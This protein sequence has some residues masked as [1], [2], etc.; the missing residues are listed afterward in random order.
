[1][2]TGSR[3]PASSVVV[4]PAAERHATLSSHIASTL[5]QRIVQGMIPDGAML[6]RQEDLQAEFDVGHPSLREALRMLET[7]GLI[8][9]RRGKHGGAVVHPPKPENAAFGIGLVLEHQ[10]TQ[11]DDV[12]RVL[13]ALDP[14]C[15]ALCAS[16]ADRSTTVLPLLREIHRENR[17]ASDPMTFFRCSR[18]FH[19]ALTAHC[20]S[21]TLALIVDALEALWSAQIAPEAVASLAANQIERALAQHEAIMAAIEAGDAD[22][23]RQLARQHTIEGLE[24]LYHERLAPAVR[25]SDRSHL[26]FAKQ[27]RRWLRDASSGS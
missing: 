18:E 4:G 15:A 16:R 9:V 3:M 2:T 1:M 27:A 14:E 13:A 5:R 21:N 6:P 20:G 19:D 26:A 24:F 22:G 23:A 7:D 25:V 10:R 17:E 11:L 8:S 12:G